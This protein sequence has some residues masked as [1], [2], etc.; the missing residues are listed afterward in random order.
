MFSAS[1][2]AETKKVTRSELAAIL[3]D[4]GKKVF[5]AVFNAQ[6]NMKEAVEKLKDMSEGTTENKRTLNKFVREFLKGR[7]VSIC[8]HLTKSE[9]KLGRSLVIALDSEG[10]SDFRQIDHRGLISIIL[11]NKKYILK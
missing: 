1:H 2:F 9:P 11:K 8:A 3:G 10:K 4:T 5:T 6:V 7:E